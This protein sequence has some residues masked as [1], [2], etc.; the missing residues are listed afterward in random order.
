MIFT[1]YRG[2]SYIRPAVLVTVSR[3]QQGA[4]A[5]VLAACVTSGVLGT[6]VASGKSGI[7]AGILGKD[8]MLRSGL[9]QESLEGSKE[10]LAVYRQKCGNYLGFWIPVWPLVKQG[11]TVT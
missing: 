6:S 8:M 3:V 2:Y 10:V 4:F 5:G 1:A 7:S 11:P 9:F